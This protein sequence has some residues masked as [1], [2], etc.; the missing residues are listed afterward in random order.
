[1][2]ESSLSCTCIYFNI[3]YIPEPYSWWYP[4]P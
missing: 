4:N 3:Q 2:V 1:M